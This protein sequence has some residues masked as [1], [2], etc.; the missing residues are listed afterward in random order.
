MRLLRERFVVLVSVVVTMLVF[1]FIISNFPV[2]SDK[3][4]GTEPVAN[5]NVHTSVE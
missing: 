2:N 5:A 4:P 3:A 1:A